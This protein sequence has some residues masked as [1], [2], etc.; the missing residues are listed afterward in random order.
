VPDLT[1]HVVGAYVAGRALRLRNLDATYYL[2]T[3]LPDVISR[4]SRF[5]C[6]PVATTWRRVTVPP[7]PSPRAWLFLSSLP[8]KRALC[9]AEPD[10]GKCAAPVVGCVTKARLRGLSLAVSLFRLPSKMRT[11][12]A[13][14]YPAPAAVPAHPGVPAPQEERSRSRP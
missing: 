10:S 5:S 4:P 12:M 11:D 14:P 8:R 6:R 9:A 3:I 13:G 2:G 1:T 7:W